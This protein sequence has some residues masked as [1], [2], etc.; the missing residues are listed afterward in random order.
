MP[1]ANAEEIMDLV[2]KFVVQCGKD[3]SGLAPDTN[4]YADGLG[5]ES[6]DAAELSARLESRYGSDPYSEGDFPQ[7]VGEIVRFYEGLPD[8]P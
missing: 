3:A 2:Q 4:L 7:T 6:L 5:L 1:R 8:S